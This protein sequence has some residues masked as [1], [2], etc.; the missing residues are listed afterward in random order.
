VINLKKPRLVRLYG[1][2]D[3]NLLYVCTCGRLAQ[4]PIKTFN[5]FV[6]CS[7][8][9]AVNDNL[10]SNDKYV[11]DEDRKNLF[12]KMLRNGLYNFVSSISS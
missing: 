1:V 3:G 7:V 9:T 6:R 4:E 5:K 2:K 11:S 12:D 10:I 8:C